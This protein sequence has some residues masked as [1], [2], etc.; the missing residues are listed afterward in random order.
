[1]TGRLRANWMLVLAGPALFLG[2]LYAALGQEN[3]TSGAPVFYPAVRFYGLSAETLS[4]A[5]LLL[6]ATLLGLWVPQ[7]LGRRPRSGRNGLA[8]AVALTGAALAC[9]GTLP[10]VFAPYLH[11]AQASLNGHVYQLGARYVADGDDV[12]VLCVCDGS[13]LTCRCHTLPAAGRPAQAQ[14][15]LLADAADGMLTIQAG[16]QRVYRFQP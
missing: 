8:V 14:T 4:T 15:Q 6:A 5:S 3:I 1:M 2:L 10:Q 12:Y 13:G 9:W 7:A 11:L 16:Q